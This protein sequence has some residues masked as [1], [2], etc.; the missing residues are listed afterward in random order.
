M[1]P[2]QDI[3]AD[4]DGKL[5]TDPDKYAFQVATK[6]VF[7]D[8]RVAQRYGITDSLISTDEPGRPVRDRSDRNSASVHIQK[9]E[10]KTEPETDK[11][12]TDEQEATEPKAAASKKAAA[13]AE[14]DK[15]K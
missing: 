14:G 6:G 1:I 13:K 7:L 15:K 5:T 2:K 11:P 9:A 10:D 3:Y 12:E 8:E 4:K